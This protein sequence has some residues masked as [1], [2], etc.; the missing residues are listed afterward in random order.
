MKTEMF[1]ALLKLQSE[2]KPVKKDAENPFF[3]SDYATLG[4]IWEAVRPVLHA[5]G[6]IINQPVR[7]Q[8]VITI[9]THVSGESIESN[10]PIVSKTDKNPQ[11]F[12]GA[13][14][15]ARKYALSALLGIVTEDDDDGNAAVPKQ[16]LNKLID[17]GF[18]LLKTLSPGLDKAGRLVAFKA[19]SK[20]IFGKEYKSFYDMPKDILE[21]F[22]AELKERVKL[23]AQ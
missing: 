11:D 22:I 9:L 13:V 17:E 21:K 10:F 12:G 2:L 6:F 8:E 16:D 7:G 15:Y 3:H 23:A 1:N 18:A 5:N 4:A 19:T 14:T 20:D